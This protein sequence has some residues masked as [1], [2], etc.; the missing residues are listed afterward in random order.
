VTTK[1][2][3][4]ASAI[5]LLAIPAVATA[6]PRRSADNSAAPVSERARR[7]FDFVDST[8]FTPV[9]PS[10]PWRYYGGPKS[11]Y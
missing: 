4:T 9:A 10:N 8:T 1:M 2:M 5:I 11:N 6:G 3:L 7:S